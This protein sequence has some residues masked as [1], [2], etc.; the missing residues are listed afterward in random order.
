MSNILIIKHGSLGDIAQISG[1][2]QDIKENYPNEKIIILTTNPYEKLFNKCPYIDEVYIDH[3]HPRWNFYYLY[4]LKKKILNLKPTKIFDLQNSSRTSFY[5]K[6]L[7]TKIFWS[8]T[9]TTLPPGKS[10]KD[11][12]NSS[13]LSRFNFQLTKSNLNTKNTL[14]PNFSWA[15]DNI[16]ELKKKYNLEKYILLFPFC[17][18]SLP[19]KKWPYY[20]E[21]ISLIEKKYPKLKLITAPGPEELN[22]AKNINALPVVENN[23]S[24][25]LTQLAGLINEAKFIIS[26]DTGPAHMSAHL[27]AKGIALFGYHTTP[28]K[29]SMETENFKTITKN[30]LKELSANEVFNNISEKLSLI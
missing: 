15:C 11:F 1:A 23:R 17:S 24:I 2:I 8:S 18:T 9:E 27:G 22:E 28:E 21:L 13:V 3:R 7:L 12:D 26:N 14:K 5:R 19:H 16:D 6:Y 30:N 20:N 10:K 4:K 29:V 25:S